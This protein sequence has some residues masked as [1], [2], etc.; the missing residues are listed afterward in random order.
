MGKLQYGM[1]VAPAKFDLRDYRAKFKGVA[2]AAQFPAVFELPMPNVKNQGQVGSCVAHSIA[3]VIEYFDNT[4]TGGTEPMST[5]YIYGNRRNSTWKDSGMRTREAL[6]NATSYGDVQKV[7][8]PQNVE[9]P[10][11]IKL[12][13]EKGDALIQEGSVNR[14]AN[15]FKLNTVSSI[16]QCLMTYGPVLVIVKWYDDNY[17]KD[18]ILHI[19][20]NSAKADG[21][22]CMVCYGWDQ[23]GWKIQNSW[24]SHWGAS[25]RTILPFN[26]KFVEVWGIA[27]EDNSK[28][29]N[30]KIIHP[31]NS[32]FGQKFAKGLNKLINLILGR[33]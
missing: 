32:Q 21:Q 24:G 9:V 33:K 16:K 31:Y 10:E 23:R 6:K 12:F 14:I 8:F 5:G 27:D 20:G 26:T 19:T 15:F 1:G 30:L 2:T 3:T 22:H 18:G 7:K 17:V 29:T 4:E 13:E 11:A 25:G 28:E